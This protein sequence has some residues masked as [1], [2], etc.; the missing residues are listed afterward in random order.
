M[1]VKRSVRLPELHYVQA[2][3]ASPEPNMYPIVSICHIPTIFHLRYSRNIAQFWIFKPFV[4]LTIR[5]FDFW[6]HIQNRYNK[7]RI[8][9][10]KIENKKFVELET[11]WKCTFSWFWCFSLRRRCFL[12]LLCN[13]TF[14][15]H[16]ITTKASKE[17]E[18]R[19]ACKSCFCSIVLI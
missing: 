17:F 2:V 19:I 10:L 12:C 5:T 6:S 18:T 8:L 1:I 3:I 11:F 16:Q 15:S 4:L 13:S 7:R 14:N 9:L